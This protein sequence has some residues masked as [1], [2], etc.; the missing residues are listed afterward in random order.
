MLQ[1]AVNNLGSSLWSEGV[2]KI[3]S[4]GSIEKTFAQGKKKCNLFVCEM[5]HCNNGFYVPLINGL[6]SKDDPP[7][8]NQW[9]GDT[10]IENWSK[11]T[12]QE[13]PQPGYVWA[14]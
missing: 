2:A 3:H 11:L 5:G 14:K 7:V 6:P 8:A 13:R 4:H 12:M 1:N 9:A 10:N